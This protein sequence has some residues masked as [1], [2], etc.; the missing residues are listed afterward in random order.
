MAHTESDAGSHNMALVFILQNIKSIIQLFFIWLAI[1]YIMQWLATRGL[2]ETRQ[3]TRL[4]I[5]VCCLNVWV[6]VFTIPW[7]QM[8]QIHKQSIKCHI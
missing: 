1:I 6:N 5:F 8:L 7:T 2:S 3:T 4:N